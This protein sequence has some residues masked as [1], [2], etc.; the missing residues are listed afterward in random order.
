M[1]RVRAFWAKY[2][3]WVR[4]IWLGLIVLCAVF[5]LARIIPYYNADFYS[6]GAAKVQ[7]LNTAVLTENGNSR[8]VKLPLEMT[9]L[10]AGTHVQV[11]F[12]FHNLRQDSYV[13]VRSAFAP[14]TVYVN[15]EKVYS[16]GDADERPSFMK[17]PGTIMTYIPIHDTGETTV[18]IFYTSPA[19]RDSLSVYLHCWYPI[20]RVLCAI[21]PCRWVESF[22][23]V[24]CLPWQG[25]F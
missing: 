24:W 10:K 11:E 14:I 16:F 15:G 19:A 21:V 23:A 25:L 17:D 22:L 1:Q 4:W 20:S 12:S 2:H 7:T 6:G 9:D 8:K 5:L 13:Q 18:T 3:T